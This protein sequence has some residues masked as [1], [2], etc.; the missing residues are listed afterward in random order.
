M[1]GIE[2]VTFVN[3]HVIPVCI[4]FIMM[5]MGLSLVFADFKRYYTIQKP[6][7]LV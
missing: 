2:L 7:L 3:S 6:L 5:G 4:F 1:E